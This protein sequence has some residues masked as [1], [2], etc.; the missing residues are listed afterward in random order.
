[1]AGSFGRA[2]L[3]GAIV[4]SFISVHYDICLYVD[5]IYISHFVIYINLV[6]TPVIASFRQ[7]S[8]RRILWF[9][10]I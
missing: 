8:L 1:M 7:S 2:F 4:Y 6:I 9:N 3:P 10:A 5:S